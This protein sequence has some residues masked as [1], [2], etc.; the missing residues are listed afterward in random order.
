MYY[1]I[2]EYRTVG[3]I[4]FW[5]PDVV[6]SSP[7]IQIPTVIIMAGFNISRIRI[8]RLLQKQHATQMDICVDTL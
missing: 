6:G 1:V 4:W 7:A 5:D 8:F 2:S 3:A